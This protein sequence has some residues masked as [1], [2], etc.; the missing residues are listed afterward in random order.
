VSA[1]AV[2]RPDHVLRR[3]YG[4][5]GE[6]EFT[7]GK[8]QL[9][10]KRWSL[11]QDVSM[12]A[13]VPVPFARL[14]EVTPGRG[15]QFLVT[16]EERVNLSSVHLQVMQL[17]KVFLAYNSVRSSRLDAPH[18]LL[19]D[20]SPSSVL[21]SSARRQET[22]GLVGY[23]YDRR[24]LTPADIA[25]ALAHPFNVH[26]GIP[27]TKKPEQYRLLLAELQR[28]PTRPLDL[29]ALAQRHAVPLNDLRKHADELVRLGVLDRPHPGQAQYHP[30]LR[31]DESWAYATSSRTFAPGSSWRRTRAPCS[32]TPRMS[33]ASSAAV[34]WPLMTSASSLPSACDS[35]SLS[36][37]T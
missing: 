19:M 36:T 7:A 6:V 34:G 15:E 9:R 8:H 13:W 14:E 32:T 18:I 5:R 35:S 22:I 2:R 4:A 24:A 26:L 37:A 29:T 28:C 25:I 20:L 12:V 21:A 11:D 27:T 3:A 1:E 30:A 16:E 31:V 33:T 23:P 17:A 10:Y